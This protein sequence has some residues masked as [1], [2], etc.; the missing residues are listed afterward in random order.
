M[1][2]PLAWICSSERIV[3]ISGAVSSGES[4]PGSSTD[5]TA[6]SSAPAA[7]SS[8]AAVIWSSARMALLGGAGSSPRTAAPFGGIR[9]S[10]NRVTMSP[11]NIGSRL[12]PSVNTQPSWQRHRPHAAFTQLSGGNHECS[13]VGT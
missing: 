4:T 5:S 12:S 13:G 6:S 7:S 1:P 3:S 10:R 2:R 9:A 11:A 8:I